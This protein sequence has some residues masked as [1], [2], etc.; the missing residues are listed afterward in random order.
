MVKNADNSN[1][2]LLY[3]IYGVNFKFHNLRLIKSLGLLCSRILNPLTFYREKTQKNI[4]N[5]NFITHFIKVFNLAR[6]SCFKRAPPPKLL[7]GIT[8]LVIKMFV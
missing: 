7:R 3:Y 1:T 8:I 2:E 6:L 5:T 4:H